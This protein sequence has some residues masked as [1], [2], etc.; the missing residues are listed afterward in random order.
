MGE[1]GAVIVAQAKKFEATD[2]ISRYHGI[3]SVW[4]NGDRLVIVEAKG[5]ASALGKTVRDGDQMGRNW[6]RAKIDKMLRDG[7]PMAVDL[8]KAFN[9][10]KL[11]AM[12]VNTP[13]GG[14]APSFLMKDVLTEVQDNAF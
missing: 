4:K 11:D 8:D 9:N 1:A 13:A 3:D 14:G 7:D 2:F 12:V 10:G 5:G 6:I